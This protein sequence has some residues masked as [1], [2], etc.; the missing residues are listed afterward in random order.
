MV[1]AGG[2]S[3]NKHKMALIMSLKAML[4]MFLFNFAF[5]GSKPDP[6]LAKYKQML[7]TPRGQM[8]L[9]RQT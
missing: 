9:K 2:R 6:D 7:Q 5:I 3:N 4:M 1:L 8:P